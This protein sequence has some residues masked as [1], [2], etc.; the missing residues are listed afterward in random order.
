MSH[1]LSDALVFSLS[2]KRPLTTTP[3]KKHLKKSENDRSPFV[4]GG[5]GGIFFDAGN[6]WGTNKNVLVYRIAASR[7]Q[8]DVAERLNA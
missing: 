7:Q 4:V 8:M 3:Q 1:L 5:Y 6:K 2:V